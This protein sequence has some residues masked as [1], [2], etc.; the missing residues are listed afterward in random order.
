[1]KKNFVLFLS[2]LL[3]IACQNKKSNSV[4]GTWYQCNNKGTYEE[5]NI[6]EHYI[7]KAVSDSESG[8]HETKI[9]LYKSDIEEQRLIITEGLNVALRG[10]SVVL[11]F[12][13]KDDNHITIIDE[14]GSGAFIRLKDKIP[15]IDTSDVNAWSKLYMDGFI[16][17][18]A[19]A[20]CDDVHTMEEKEH[21]S[22][23][24][25]AD[26]QISLSLIL[27][28][29][30]VIRTQIKYWLIKSITSLLLMKFICICGLRK[31]MG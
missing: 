11:T 28:H 23:G 22:A 26:D 3:I 12:A 31:S 21:S 19:R 6:S 1:M 10:K 17:R 24:V 5:W 9:A 15:A 4:I 7:S 13:V 18:A 14:S 8:S 29:L 16:K 30:I 25:S 2:G 20:H 27:L